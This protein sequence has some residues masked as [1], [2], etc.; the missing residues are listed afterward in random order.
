MQ[1]PPTCKCD[2]KHIIT[3]WIHI[4]LILHTLLLWLQFIV[5]VHF[6]VNVLTALLYGPANGLAELKKKSSYRHQNS[7]LFFN[8]K[9]ISVLRP[10][11]GVHGQIKKRT[12]GLF[13]LVFITFAVLHL[14]AIL[15]QKSRKNSL[16][17]ALSSAAKNEQ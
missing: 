10:E 4:I 3:G 17:R 2:L 8:E 7:V 14:L 16:L 11:K 6:Q 15:A 5:T 9:P 1:I 13:L 12:T